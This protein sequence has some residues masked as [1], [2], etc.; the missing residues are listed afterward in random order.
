MISYENQEN[1]GAERAPRV[2]ERRGSVVAMLTGDKVYRERCIVTPLEA[3]TG[4]CYFGRK[5]R[6]KCLI[7]LS[8]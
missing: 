5:W 6:L 3:S 1:A 4:R 7:L 2:S 8:F